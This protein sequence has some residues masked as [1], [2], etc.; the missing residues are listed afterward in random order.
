MRLARRRPY[1]I[2]GG[3]GAVACDGLAAGHGETPRG[4]GARSQPRALAAKFGEG[5]EAPGHARRRKKYRFDA[6]RRS[7]RSLSGGLRPWAL[8]TPGRLGRRRRARPASLIPDRERFRPPAASR[9]PC[10]PTSFLCS[11]ADRRQ[12]DPG[13]PAL[14]PSPGAVDERSPL[15]HPPGPQRSLAARPPHRPEVKTV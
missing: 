15:D 14:M 5:C 12:K 1:G 8:L 13:A 4:R 10:H 11:R 9:R 7:A 2:D 6:D 3:E